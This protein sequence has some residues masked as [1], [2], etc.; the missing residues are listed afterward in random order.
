[1]TCRTTKPLMLSAEAGANVNHAPWR[2]TILL[3]FHMIFYI[4][5]YLFFFQWNIA[6]CMVIRE[7]GVDI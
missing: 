4:D 7:F 6:R 1:M 5:Y 2:N 3:Y